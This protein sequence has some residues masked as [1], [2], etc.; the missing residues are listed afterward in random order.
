MVIRGAH[1][2]MDLEKDLL[3]FSAHV[4]GF[5]LARDLFNI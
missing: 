5:V 3:Y 4:D 1:L 2:V